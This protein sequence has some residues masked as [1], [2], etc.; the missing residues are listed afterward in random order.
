MVLL[1]MAH[2]LWQCRE[3]GWLRRGLHGIAIRGDVVGAHVRHYHAP[4]ATRLFH[5]AMLLPQK[6][7]PVEHLLRAIGRSLEAFAELGVFAFEIGDALGLHGAAIAFGGPQPR[8]G[9]ERPTPKRRE[10]VAEVADELFQFAPGEQL[11]TFA[12]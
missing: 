3:Q 9:L 6:P 12:V 1:A 2:G 4:R 11:R 5:E 10:L 7:E 8:L